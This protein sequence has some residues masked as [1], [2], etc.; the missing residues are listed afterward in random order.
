M[1]TILLFLF[2]IHI[3]VHLYAQEIKMNNIVVPEKYSTNFDKNKLDSL[4]TDSEFQKSPIEG[5]WI[6][7]NVNTD[8]LFF[9]PYYDGQ[10]PIFILERGRKVENQLPKQNSGMYHYRLGN[11]F[12]KTHWGFSSNL[13]YY[14]YYFRLSN[15]SSE[16]KIGNFYSSSHQDYDTLVFKRVDK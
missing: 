7:S 2:T 13:S 16:I 6:E 10:D 15:D 11:N 14:S 1:K 9:F 5:I 8:T 4:Y 12:I 3:S